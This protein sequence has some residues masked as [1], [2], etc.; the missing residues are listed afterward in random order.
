VLPPG[1]R[2]RRSG[3]EERRARGQSCW[4][5]TTA[6]AMAVGP[7]TCPMC[8]R[9]AR[10]NTRARSIRP[11]CCVAVRRP[12]TPPRPTQH[13]D[14]KACSAWAAVVERRPR[15]GRE[16]VVQAAARPGEIRRS[17]TESAA[18]TLNLGLPGREPLHTPHA[19]AQR[20]QARTPPH[21]GTPAL[22]APATA[23]WR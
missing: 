15:G 11:W 8:L 18:Q 16:R 9:E 13:F 3:R 1:E 21:D 10:R 22:A 17:T 6:T 4:C 19:Q 2:A 12:P 20:D 14:V 7:H 23:Q 5:S